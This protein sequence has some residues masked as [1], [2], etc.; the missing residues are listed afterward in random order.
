MEQRCSC[1]KYKPDLVPAEIVEQ[2]LAA[3][4]YA[5]T[6]MNRQSPIIIAVSNKDLHDEMSKLNA[7]VMGYDDGGKRNKGA[8]K[9]N[10]IYRVN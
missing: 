10:Y 5:A 8:R 4:T 9:E 1:R 7:G 3:G 2:I 6:G